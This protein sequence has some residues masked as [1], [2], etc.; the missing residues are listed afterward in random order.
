ML[1]S[2]M[3]ASTILGVCT[4]TLR[5]WNGSGTFLPDCR[6]VGGHR[7][8]SVPK[9]ESFL[10]SRTKK[11]EK[12]AP[13]KL[14]EHQNIN[15]FQ[16]A[17]IYARVSAMKQKEDLER[18]I[19]YLTQQAREAGFNEILI[20]KDIAS[21]LNDARNGLKRLIRDA[22]AQKFGVVFISHRD[23]LARF[24]TALINQVLNLL[25]IKIQLVGLTALNEQDTNSPLNALV[26]DVLAILTSYSGK[27]Y[28]LRRASFSERA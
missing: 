15:K 10:S 2:I 17:A 23:R 20:Y 14:Q 16:N 8:Y 18:Q 22:F 3:Q 6:T 19:T 28:R 5:R 1:L 4:K 25:H 13:Y 7:R 21:G 9:L 26:T 11:N 24:G 12:V 27:L